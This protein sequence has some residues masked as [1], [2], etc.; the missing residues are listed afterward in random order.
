MNGGDGAVE[1]KNTLENAEGPPISL[2]R[3]R[4][5]HTAAGQ[6]GVLVLRERCVRMRRAKFITIYH[7]RPVS[8]GTGWVA[9][10]GFSFGFGG[11]GG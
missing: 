8:N 6:Y 3:A 11:L 7:R 4:R 9:A 2:L 1:P 10:C 5:F